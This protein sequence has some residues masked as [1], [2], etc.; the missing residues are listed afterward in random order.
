MLQ[1]ITD[2]RR[3]KENQIVLIFLTA[4]FRWDRLAINKSDVQCSTAYI[5]TYVYVR[6][7]IRA[8][9]AFQIN[10]CNPHHLLSFSNSQ[11]LRN[12]VFSF[13][14]Y[15]AQVDFLIQDLIFSWHHRWMY[16]FNI[17]STKEEMQKC[18]SFDLTIQVSD[19]LKFKINSANKEKLWKYLFLAFSVGIEFS[20]I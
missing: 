3:V 4:G 7:W 13:C 1:S 2:L 10:T 19:F 18:H 14:R 15:F 9:L 20:P 5:C 6:Q 11:R 12:T 17:I 8:I 16:K